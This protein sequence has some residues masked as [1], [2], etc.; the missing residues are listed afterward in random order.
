MSTPL[1]RTGGTSPTSRGGAGRTARACRTLR[2][3]GS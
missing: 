2:S 3:G 1:R